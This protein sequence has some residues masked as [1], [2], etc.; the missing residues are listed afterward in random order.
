MKRHAPILRVPEAAQSDRSMGLPAWPDAWHV[1]ARSSDLPPGKV[2]SLSLARRELVIYRTAAGSLGALDAYCPHMGAHLGGAVV[3]GASLICPLHRYALDPSGTVCP[4]GGG[5]ACG[6][7]PGARAY[8]VTEAFGLV[9]VHPGGDGTQAS[10]APEPAAGMRWLAGKPLRLRAD[11]RHVMVN[12][13]D[14]LHMRSVHGRALTGPA[15]IEERDGALSMS[16]E[17]GVAPRSDLAGYLTRGL[18]QNRIKVRQTCSGPWLM[19]ESAVGPIR[20]CAVFG[21]L[22][23]GGYLRV[24]NAFGTSRRG[25]LAFWGL[26]LVRLFYYAF[27]RKDFALLEGMRLRLGHAEDEGVSAIAA[28]LESFRDLDPAEG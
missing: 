6:P 2:R 7:I 5:R 25:P 18:S 14:L 26:R 1:V 8:P 4:P 20:T 12:A 10:P 28:Y 19:V 17:S 23:E 11:W 27:L 13:F 16:Y 22:Q 15:R 3:Q 21:L 24:F 9:F